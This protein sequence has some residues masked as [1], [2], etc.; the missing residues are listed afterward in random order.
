M[1]TIYHIYNFG[2]FWGIFVSHFRKCP[3]W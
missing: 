2:V 1:L 3:K